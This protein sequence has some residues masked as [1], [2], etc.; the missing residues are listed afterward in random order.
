MKVVILG[1]AGQIGRLTVAEALAAGH[2]VTAFARSPERLAA[3]GLRLLAGDVTAEADVRAAVEGQEAVVCT[4]GAPLNSRTL[5]H[6]PTLC[7]TAAGHVITA[8]K[9]TGARRLVCST[10]IGVGDSRGHGRFVF[11]NVIQPVLLQRIFDDRER[12]E[13]LIRSSDL[14]WV[15]VRPA[16]LTDG[17]ASPSGP[18]ALLSPYPDDATRVSRADVAKFLVRQLATDQ[19]LGRTPLLAT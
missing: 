12:Q 4:F 5:L 9:A 17:P 10:A 14:D 19:F 8:M 18:R 16:E 15:I 11:R 13:A 1:A 6:P 3:E 2:E 7:A